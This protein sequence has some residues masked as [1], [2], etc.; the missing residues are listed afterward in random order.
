MYNWLFAISCL[1]VIVGAD[2]AL[3]SWQKSK[4][5]SGTYIVLYWWNAAMGFLYASH[6]WK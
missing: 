6:T 5:L 3:R 2:G 1:L 4:I